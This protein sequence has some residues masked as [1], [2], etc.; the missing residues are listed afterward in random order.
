M[1]VR[2]GSTQGRLAT[3]MS[4][5]AGAQDGHSAVGA[6]LEGRGDAHSARED[7]TWDSWRR[8]FGGRSTHLPHRGREKRNSRQS[9]RPCKGWVRLARS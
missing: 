6:Q 9:Q 5:V 4:L 1:G 8:H 2:L 7:R 3:L